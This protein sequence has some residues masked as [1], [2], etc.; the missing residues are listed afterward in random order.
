M[1][2]GR[3]LSTQDEVHHIDG[4]HG[5]NDPKNRMVVSKKKHGSIHAAQKERDAFGRFIVNG[6]GLKPSPSGETLR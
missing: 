1:A 2:E 3:E 5:N 4:D 6:M